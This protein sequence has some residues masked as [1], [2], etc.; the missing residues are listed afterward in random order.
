MQTDK[1]GFRHGRNG[2]GKGLQGDGDRL[3]LKVLGHESG[4]GRGWVM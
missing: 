1:F 3:G 4:W 2:V